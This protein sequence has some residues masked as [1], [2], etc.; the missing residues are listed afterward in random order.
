MSLFSRSTPDTEKYVD[1][2]I[3]GFSAGFQKAFDMMTP[4]IKDGLTKSAKI[5]HDEA[6]DETLKRLG[7][8]GESHGN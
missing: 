4:I 6:V 8:G 7:L 2:F 1:I 5:L 3:A